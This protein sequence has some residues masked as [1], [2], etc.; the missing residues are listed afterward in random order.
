[1]S[2]AAER[3]ARLIEGK[4]DAIEGFV[5]IVTDENDGVQ[6]IALDDLRE[7]MHQPPLIESTQAQRDRSAYDRGY[8]DALRDAERAL[9]ARRSKTHWASDARI[10][11]LAADEVVKLAH[12]EAAADVA[13]LAWV[14]GGKVGRIPAGAFPLWASPDCAHGPQRQRRDG[15]HTICL[16]CGVLRFGA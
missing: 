3:I 8:Q 13:G 1:M 10:L 6:R 5:N 11:K 7:I 4:S 12:P 16:D 2:T 15:R 14:I 9:L